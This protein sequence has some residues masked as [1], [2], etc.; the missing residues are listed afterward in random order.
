MRI[1]NVELLPIT[2]EIHWVIL[3]FNYVRF[4]ITIRIIFFFQWSFGVILWELTTLAQQPY[5]EIDPFE[6]SNYLEKGYRLFQP[7]GCPDEL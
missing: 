6:M 7:I 1:T 5:V 4:L 2:R 3:L